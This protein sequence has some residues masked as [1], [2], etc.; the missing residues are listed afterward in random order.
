MSDYKSFHWMSDFEKACKDNLTINAWEKLLG[1]PERGVTFNR[2]E[3]MFKR[4]VQKEIL[5]SPNLWKS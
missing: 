5:T 4:Y 1:Y 3:E 2:N